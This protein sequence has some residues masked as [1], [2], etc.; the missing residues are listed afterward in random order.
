MSG[1]GER[2]EKAT[3]KRLREARREGRIA[4][5]AE[6]GAW[7]GMLAASLLLPVVVRSTTAQVI[8]MRGQVQAVIADPSPGR[9]LVL[10]K[11]G[12]LG[13]ATAVAPLAVGLLAVAVAASA[14]EGGLHR[15][16]KLLLPKFSRLNP[17][18]G[19]KRIFGP[20]AAWETLKALLKTA[21]I[22]LVLYGSVRHLMTTLMADGV[23]PLPVLL[24]A[25]GGSALA[26]V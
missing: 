3:P 7:A 5:S 21:V 9:L 12:M 20:H 2:T 17:I 23:L 13:A 19:I 16:T 6:V 1:G 8:G 15:A 14:A 24:Q 22:G 11:H 10:L 25:V 4:R 18:P 26:L